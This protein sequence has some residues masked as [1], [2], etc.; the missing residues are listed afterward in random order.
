MRGV[1]LGLRRL[2]AVVTAWLK[3]QVV[4]PGI[5]GLLMEPEAVTASSNF[6]YLRL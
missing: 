5:C 6:P 3:A 1:T 2:K 4:P